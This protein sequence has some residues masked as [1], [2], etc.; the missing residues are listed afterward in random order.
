MATPNTLGI[1]G[2]T[3][4]PPHIGHVNAGLAFLRQ[5]K[6]DRMIVMPARIPPHKPDGGIDP[7]HRLRMTQ[8]AFEDAPEYGET[9]F[10][11]DWEMTRQSVS[12]TANTLRFFH[13]QGYQLYF[14]C[15]TDMFLTLDSWRQPDQ[16][17]SLATIA[18]IRREDE[19]PVIRQMIEDAK[20]NYRIKYN[21][22]PV[23][24]VTKP[25][26]ISSSDIRTGLERGD[27]VSGQIPPAVLHYIREHGLYLPAERSDLHE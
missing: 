10:V 18:Y 11:S 3:F 14:L 21:A 27:D 13:M 24:I 22:E 7:I 23:E 9:L 20:Y 8:L 26:E 4:S 15:G 17:F 6:L 16:I 19:T 25:I 12:Y 1:Y 2:G 5:L